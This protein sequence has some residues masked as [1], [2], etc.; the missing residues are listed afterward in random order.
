MR[1]HHVFFLL[2]SLP[3]L[4]TCAHTQ[5]PEFNEREDYGLVENNAI[6]EASGLAASSLNSGVLWTHN[7]SGDSTRVFAMTVHGHDL[8]DFYLEGTSARDWEDIAVGSGPEQGVSYI[9]VGEIGDNAAVYQTK[10]IYRV[11]EPRVDSSVSPTSHS[12]SGVE[13]ITYRYPDG[14]RDAEAL[15]VDPLTRDLII[16]SKREA[17]VRVYRLPYPQATDSTITLEH[18]ATLDSITF[19]TGGDISVDGTE[20]LLKNYAAVYYWG[21]EDKNESIA[22]LFQRKPSRL[23]YTPEPQGEA[24]AWSPDGLGYY[25]VSEESRNIPARIFFYERKNV[26]AVQEEEMEGSLYRGGEL[27]LSAVYSSE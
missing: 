2:I 3:F 14:P 13:T 18:I 23:P 10:R 15:M 16:V 27:N 19:I 7:D 9:Y 20:I 26:S 17:S 21:R 5:P 24:I 25:T 1:L 11:P 12:L 4:A 6:N 22:K 8:G